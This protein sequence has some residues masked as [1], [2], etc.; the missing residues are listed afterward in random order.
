[1]REEEWVGGH[2]RPAR[3]P[4]FYDSMVAGPMSVPLGG[5]DSRPAAYTLESWN[6]GIVK[7]IGD[8]ACTRVSEETRNAGA[9]RGE[10][11]LWHELMPAS[12]RT[13]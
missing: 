6:K 3:W 10:E 12:R 2:E 7:V 1:M 4:S 13:F 9:D 11:V 5:L 8:A